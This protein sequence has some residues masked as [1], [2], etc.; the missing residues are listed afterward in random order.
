M[1]VKK[2]RKRAVS[3]ARQQR[4]DSG[5]HRLICEMLEVG[6]SPETP[7]PTA[8]EAVC[9]LRQKV[10]AALLYIDRQITKKDLQKILEAYDDDTFLIQC[11]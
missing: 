3:K 4:Y 8:Y 1:K 6:R 7:G 5:Q 11:Y 2:S 10:D 9:S